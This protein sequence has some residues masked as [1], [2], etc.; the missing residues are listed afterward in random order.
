MLARARTYL[1]HTAFIISAGTY[2]P[3]IS[4]MLKYTEF[5]NDMNQGRELCFSDCFKSKSTQK[6]I[7]SRNG[8]H[9]VMVFRDKKINT[10]KPMTV[11][12]SLDKENKIVYWV[13]N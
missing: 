8:I 1:L 13:R 7:A 3:S 4:L 2:P 5:L 9:G 6:A 11:E 12:Q 10:K